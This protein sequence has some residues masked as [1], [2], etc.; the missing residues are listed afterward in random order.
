MKKPNILYIMS[1]QQKFSTLGLKIGETEVTPFHNW[2]ES[3]G[4]SFNS[5]YSNSA[6]CTPSRATVM[7]GVHPLV[8]GVTCHQNRA[9]FNLKQMPEILMENGYYTAASGH[10][11]R[12]RNLCRGYY[13]QVS[14]DEPGI[15]NKTIEYMYSSCGRSDV[16]WSSGL[17]NIRPENAHAAL[18][19]AKT[20]NMLDRI[21]SSNLPYFLHVAYIEP[22]PP[23]F[24]PDGYSDMFD[25]A[26]IKMPN[27]GDDLLRPKWQKKAMEDC[28]SELATEKD[29]KNVLQ[30]YYALT[31]YVSDQMQAL[32]NEMKTRGMLENTWV[33]ISSDHGDFTGEKGIFSKC[34]TLYDCLLHVPLIIIP[35]DNL[36]QKYRGMKINE[37]VELCDLFPT[38][39]GITGTK[40]PEYAQGKDLIEWLDNKTNVELHQ[41]V[42]AQ[43]GDYHGNLKT[44]FPGG[45]FRSGRH[46]SLVQSVR[47]KKYSYIKDPDYGNE[48]YDLSED[49]LELNN[50]L[51]GEAAVPDEIKKLEQYQ[52]KW[53]D[54]CLRLRKKLNIIPGDRGFSEEITIDLYGKSIKNNAGVQK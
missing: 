40:I 2:A 22:H 15:L 32:Y 50:L 18:I 23:Y 9:P 36:K 44:T 12:N 30:H 41:Y 28:G 14:H 13:E 1:D 48:A 39:L 51:D 7:T 49:P 47:N 11:E 25:I 16:G 33:I 5:A 34:E 19:N 45:M 42:C 31:R 54:E 27:I 20:V 10:Y 24:S 37:L 43:A 46:P 4:I 3:E 38:I 17:Q 52:K 53:R 6:I 8:H 35:P 21:Q 26:H 29:Y